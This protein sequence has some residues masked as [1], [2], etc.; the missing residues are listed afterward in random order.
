MDAE[1]V[2]QDS[3]MQIKNKLGKIEPASKFTSWA[4]KVLKYNTID[5]YRKRSRRAEKLNKML[6]ESNQNLGENYDIPLMFTLRECLKKVG[7]ANIRYAR[8]LNFIY[9]GQDFDYICQRLTLTRNNAYSVL[10]R[11]RTMLMKCMDTGVIE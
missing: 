10:S 8:I 7:R 11:A 2:I 1:D 5:Y 9:Q 3:L 6:R 4:L